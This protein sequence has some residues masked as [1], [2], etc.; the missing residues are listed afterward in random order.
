M[1]RSSSY[2]DRS[3]N[4]ECLIFIYLFIIIV[5]K[6]LKSFKRILLRV[7]YKMTKITFVILRFIF[8]ISSIN[9]SDIL[10]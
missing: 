4:D 7:S 5:L 2:E 9:S 10:S 3:Y 8:N 6:T 1:Y